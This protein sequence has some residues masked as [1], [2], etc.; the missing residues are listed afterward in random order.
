MGLVRQARC[1]QQIW[2]REEKSPRCLARFRSPSS[3]A[4]PLLQALAGGW[5]DARVFLF[6]GVGG[7]LPRP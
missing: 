1:K 3:P 5:L 7:G 2:E 6:R 4:L